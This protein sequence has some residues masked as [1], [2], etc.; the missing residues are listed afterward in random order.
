V[1]APP[2]PGRCPSCRGPMQV[3]KLACASCGTEVTGSYAPCPVCRLE[4]EHRRLFDLFLETRGN[5]KDVQ[6]RLQVSYPTTRQRIEEL[7]SALGLGEA[8]AEERPAPLEVLRKVREGQL[9]V[10]QAERLLR[11]EAAR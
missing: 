5:L 9:T 10:E 8:S 4:P 3:E 11:G 7:F 1:N 2:L 6:R